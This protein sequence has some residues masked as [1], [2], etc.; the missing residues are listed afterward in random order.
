M[1]Y[2]YLEQA[3]LREPLYLTWIVRFLAHYYKQAGDET[4]HV[5][6]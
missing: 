1:R 2:K 3:Q 6:H 5:V 4:S